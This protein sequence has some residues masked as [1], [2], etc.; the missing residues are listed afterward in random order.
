MYNPNTVAKLQHAVR[1]GSYKMFKE[2]TALANDESR[3][4]CTI[5]GLLR[6]K[7]GHAIPL[8]EVEPA[9]EIVKRFKTGAMSLGS[10]SREAHENLAIAMNRLGGKSNT[11]EGGEDPVR[12]RPRRERRPAA[13]RDQAGGLGPLRR[14]Q[15]LPGQRRRAPDQDGAGREARRGRPAPRAQGRRVHREDPLLDAGRRPDLPAAAPRHLLD[16]GP[17]AAHP[18]PE[19]LQQPGA[20]QREAGR[21]GR[22]SARSPPAC[23]RRRPTSC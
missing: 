11:G 17:G 8:D 7:S 10:I 20:R 22:A 19:E 5:R 4:L 3:R 13:Q 1:A 6:F 14:H 23:P 21:R 12:Y 16:R 9:S 2:Y 18:R 15:L